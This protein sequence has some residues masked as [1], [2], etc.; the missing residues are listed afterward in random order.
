M[1][2]SDNTPPDYSRYTIEELEDVLANV[3]RV[4]YA[5][6]YAEAKAMLEQKLT[7]RPIQPASELTYQDVAV[8][9]PSWSEMHAITRIV[10]VVFL[11][12]INAIE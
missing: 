4:K 1:L 5:M 7:E 11:F 6:R 9:K 10:I 8:A 2:T 12:H 3:D